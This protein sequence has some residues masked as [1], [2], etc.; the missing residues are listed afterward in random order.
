[1][2]IKSLNSVGGFSVED[3]TGN[4]VIVIDGSGNISAA[5]LSVSGIST[6]GSNANV[7]ITGGTNGQYLKTDGTGNLSWSSGGG[8][9]TGFFFVNT[10]TGN[11][12]IDVLA[13]ALTIVGR[14]GNVNVYIT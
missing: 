13:G 3:N 7:K 5:D 10:R 11:V 8:G 1:M 2:A 4:V 6:L 9:G 14:S 12:Q